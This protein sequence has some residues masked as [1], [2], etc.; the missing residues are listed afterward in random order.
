MTERRAPRFRSTGPGIVPSAIRCLC[1]VSQ[2]LFEYV[3]GIRQKESSV[4]YEDIVIAP[5]CMD[6]HRSG[7]KARSLTKNGR[8][9]VKYDKTHLE[10]PG[11]G[12]NESPCSPERKR[13]KAK[14]DGV[15]NQKTPSPLVLTFYGNNHNTFYK[16][17]LNEGVSIQSTGTVGYDD[18]TVL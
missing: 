17:L 3:L 7:P 9:S 13:E 6:T 11:P 2:Y 8:I 15:K 5:E 4:C 1:A 14:G 16:M 12:K 10:V 18:N